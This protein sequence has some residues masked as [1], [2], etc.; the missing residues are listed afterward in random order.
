MNKLFRK[1][2]NELSPLKRRTIHDRLYRAGRELRSKFKSN[3][4]KGIGVK[5]MWG[6]MIDPE[7]GYYCIDRQSL[8]KY[9]MTKSK[10][11]RPPKLLSKE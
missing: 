9:W 3:P 8:K 4:Q 7:T 5:V 1:D 6:V 11:G 10:G 2:I